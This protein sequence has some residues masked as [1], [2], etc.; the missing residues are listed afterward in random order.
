[1]KAIVY[2]KKNSNNKLV[3]TDVEKPVPADSEVLVK[4]HAVSLNAADY[5]S[6]K[7]GIIPKKKIFGADIA[8]IVESIGKDVTQFSHG[9]EVFGDL[10]LSFGGL[11]EY[12]AAPERLLAFKPRNLSFEEAA[13]LP[14]A[15]LT[16]LQAIRDEGE[17]K[18][19]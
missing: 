12:V 17:I 11:A 18:E 10:S 14:L 16:A 3:Y 7:M 8:G 19:G 15:S 13:A 5:R 2:N 1:M 6:M 9:D 4:I